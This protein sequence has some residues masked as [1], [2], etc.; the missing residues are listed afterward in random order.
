MVVVRPHLR[1][2]RGFT[3]VEL[4]VAV[5]II[6]ILTLIALQLFESLAARSRIT[7]AQSDAK[8]IA[9]AVTIY[10][11]HIGTLPASLNDLTLPAV[12]AAG[13]SAGPFLGTVPQPPSATWSPYTLT[14]SPNGTFTITASGD[15]VTITK[16]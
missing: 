3:L 14:P 13:H 6:S 11:S 5:A 10:A 15:G 7:R 9:T 16:P 2:S 4:M 8:T 12:N 1:D